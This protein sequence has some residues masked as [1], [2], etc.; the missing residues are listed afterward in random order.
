MQ[1]HTSSHTHRTGEPQGV[2]VTTPTPWIEEWFRIE[3]RLSLPP[4]ACKLAKGSE[5]ATCGWAEGTNRDRGCVS[6]SWG[7]L[8]LQVWGSQGCIPVPRAATGPTGAADDIAC[9]CKMGAEH[10]GRMFGAQALQ[11]MPC[12]EVGLEEHVLGTKVYHSLRRGGWSVC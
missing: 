8:H 6:R 11:G 5:K 7:G 2:F 3:L 1:Y 4:L 9:G 12:T 10:V